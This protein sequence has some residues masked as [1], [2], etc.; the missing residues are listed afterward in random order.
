MSLDLNLQFA[1]GLSK[2]LSAPKAKHALVKDAPQSGGAELRAGSASVAPA[3]NPRSLLK[4][5]QVQSW[6]Q[7]ALAQTNP[8]L[9]ATI[10]VRVVAEEEGRK[11][12]HLYRSKDHATNVLTFTY[13]QEEPHLLHADMVLCAPVVAREAHSQGASLQA[14]YVHL[15][16][17]GTLHAQGYDH[18]TEAQAHVMEFL[19]TQIMLKLGFGDPYMP[20]QQKQAAAASTDEQES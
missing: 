11:L 6:I 14:H 1:E 10:T 3:H 5:S 15:I 7:M 2:A 20:Q 19:E 18:E 13:P 16:I 4:R 8:K 9:Q 17:H 12:N